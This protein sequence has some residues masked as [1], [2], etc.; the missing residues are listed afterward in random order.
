MRSRPTGR[1]LRAALIAAAAVA[2]APLPGSAQYLFLDVDGDSLNTGGEFAPWADTVNVDVYAVTDRTPYGEPVT[3]DSEEGPLSIY[4]F[5]AA[6]TSALGPFELTGIEFPIPGTSPTFPPDVHPY[7]LTIGY[8][9]PS[10]LPPGKHRLLRL[11]LV[12]GEGGRNLEFSP[13][14]CHTLPGVG[15]TITSLCPGEDYDYTMDVEGIGFGRYTDTWNR[16]PTVSAPDTVQAMEGEPVSFPV[17]V[18]D[19]ECGLGTYLFSYWPLDVPTGAVV[20]GLTW[21]PYG[22]ATST[23]SWT[24]AVGQAGTYAVRFLVHDPD[25]W[26]IFVP[27]DVV[28]TTHVVVAPGVPLSANAA[29]TARAGGPYSG[30]VGGSISFRGDA[31]SDPEGEPLVFDWSFGD[32]GT[33][34]GPI[35]EYAYANPGVFVVTLT[36]TDDGGLS[37]AEPTTAAVSGPYPGAHLISAIA[38]NPVTPATVV[39]FAT[40]REGFASVHLFDARGRLVARPFERS[41]LSAGPHQ[42][43]ALGRA[44]SDA[45][46]PSGVY[47][48]RLRTEHDGAET[49]RVTLIR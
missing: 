1:L 37:A 18:F 36:V 49:R 39:A 8:T 43:P 15:I 30:V 46:L 21:A 7:G 6:F 4:G 38:P 32:G 13:G 12:Y 5:T 26:N 33:A 31:S 29:P 23:F 35:V 44:A 2:W 42:V 47:F 22:E 28:D 14:S 3:C 19:P 27:P 11:R 10:W 40:S 9:W 17:D 48:L 41:N 34:A 24:P 25:T 45:R 20:T 16:R